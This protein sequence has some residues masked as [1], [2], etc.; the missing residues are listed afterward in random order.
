MKHNDRAQALDILLNCLQTEQPLSYLLKKPTITPFTKALCFGV[1]RYY[2]RLE[3]MAD[4]C[5]DKRP[6]D[7]SVWLC[8]LLGLYQIDHMS[9]PDYA[10]VQETVA[11]LQ[12]I[13]KS[14]AK[15][16]VNAILRRFCRERNELKQSLG[17]DPIFLYAH[18]KWFIKKI[19]QDWPSSWEA[20]LEA[21]NTHPPMSLRINQHRNSSKIYQERLT[22]M[23]IPHHSIPHTGNGV[24]LEEPCDVSDVPGFSEGDI[25]VQDGAAQLA[26][27]LLHLK[28]GLRV[29]DACCAPGGKTGQ[30]LELEP[31]LEACVGI[32][33][34]EKRLQ[35]V[36][37]NC[38]RL[39]V[40][41]MLRQGDAAE[42]QA[43]WDGT[44]FDRI[45]LDAPCSATGIIRRHPDIKLLRKKAEIEAITH[46]QR[47]I[48]E[49]LW[50]LLK[51][52][53]IL[54]YATCSIMP[55]ENEQ[56]IATFVAQH[57]DA[58]VTTTTQPWGHATG[59]G[60]QIL[61]G[62]HQM[63][64]FFYAQLSKSDAIC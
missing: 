5:V 9:L 64:G 34:D 38:Q 20:I 28:P 2:S 7:L 55:E 35:R 31:Q 10:V 43:W 14:W 4:Q 3:R 6:K 42:P 22:Q 18:P 23:G 39:N 26:G 47:H 8:I 36:H 27:P 33:I 62:E 50:P 16:F 40:H 41:P 11:L 44:L 46:V 58:L 53:G 59:H 15:G 29:L 63:D 52:G 1:T 56:Q 37:D 17:D 51:P 25:S 21:N 49:A 32:D 61:P 45:L 19:Q 30:I 13:K 12:T 60:W 54:V 24:I 57:P 48:L